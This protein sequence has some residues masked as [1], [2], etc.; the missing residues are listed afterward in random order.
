MNSRGTNF[1]E[2]RFGAELER[3]LDRAVRPFDPRVIVQE[4]MVRGRPSL[5]RI[6]LATAAIVVAAVVAVTAIEALGVS[7]SRLGGPGPAET[8]APEASA[9]P[10]ETGLTKG[11]VPDSA[12]LPD[13]TIDRSQ[14][15]DFIPALD[16]DDAVGWISRDHAFPVDGERP[17]E[18][19][20]YA[21]DLR[22]VIGHHVGGVGFVP[23]GADP[24]STN[25]QPSTT[26]WAEPEPAP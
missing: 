4:A 11:P 14:V 6:T 17:R 23:I 2:Q 19:P 21:D 10:L 26:F 18:I 16:G 24:G 7:P 9:S 12:W 22:T 25:P 15:P 13:G 8:V 20:V 3:Q 1:D 5:L